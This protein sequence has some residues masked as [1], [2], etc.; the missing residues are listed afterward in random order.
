MRQ[1]QSA[2]KIIIIKRRSIKLISGGCLDYSKHLNRSQ[3]F[4][5][6]VEAAAV[7]WVNST[8]M[9]VVEYTVY[10]WCEGAAALSPH[11]Y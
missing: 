8:V 10:E 2:T 6:V 9:K 1:E 11:S 7:Y 5:T 4:K 3:A